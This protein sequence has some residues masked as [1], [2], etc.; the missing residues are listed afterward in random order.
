MSLLSNTKLRA[1]RRTR[2]VRSHF[3]GFHGDAIS[4]W[5]W[6]GEL[7]SKRTRVGLF[8]DGSLVCEQIA[9]QFRPDLK[10]AGIGD[11]HHAF[12]FDLAEILSSGA[13]GSSLNDF[14]LRTIE[15]RIS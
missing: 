4:G 1:V 8:I 7:G 3:D 14:T 2:T 9:D 13:I 6:E 12:R 5:V 15:A 10:D 11:G